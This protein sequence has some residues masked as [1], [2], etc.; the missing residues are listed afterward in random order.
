[1]PVLVLPGD[2]NSGFGTLSATCHANSRRPLLAGSAVSPLQGRV[3]Y[4]WH[5][6]PLGK[7]E[8]LQFDTAHGRHL[9]IRNH[10]RRVVEVG[11]PQEVLGRSKGM[12]GVSQRPEEVVGCDAEG[13][14]V[15]NDRNY[16]GARHN[17][18]SFTEWR[19]YRAP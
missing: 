18:L 9:D 3:E 6:V 19:A 8:G 16:W 10:A 5:E 11:R 12:D 15:V 4:E 13:C 2:F 17:G 7:Q 14:V 1:M